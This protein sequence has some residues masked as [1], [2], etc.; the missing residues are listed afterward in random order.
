MVLGSNAIV[1]FS[2]MPSEAAGPVADSVTPT[3]ISAWAEVTVI[4]TAVSSSERGNFI[5]VSFG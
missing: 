3:L 5:F 2:G 4:S 1:F